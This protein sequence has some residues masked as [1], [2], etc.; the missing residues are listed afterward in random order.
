MAD[1]NPDTYLSDKGGGFNPDAYL[2]GQRNPPPAPQ[3]KS[4]FRGAA[5]AFGLAAA[6]EAIK[7]GGAIAGAEVGAEGGA[8]LG[9]M[10][11][12]AAPITVP[13]GTILGGLAGGLAGY[14][15][16]GK[17][18]EKFGQKPEDIK[19]QEAEH[20]TASTLGRAAVDVPL[21]GAGLYGLAKTLAPAAGGLVKAG[22]GVPSRTTEEIAKAFEKRGYK[23]EPGQLK[24]DDPYHSPG[25]LGNKVA[26]QKL[27]NKEVSTVTGKAAGPKGVDNKFLNERFESL[28]KKYDDIIDKAPEWTIDR[29]AIDA[30]KEILSTERA[31]V[32]GQVRPV[33]QVASQVDKAFTDAGAGGANVTS[34]KVPAKDLKRTLSELKKI[35]RTSRDG[36][37]KFAATSAIDAIT[38]S[39]TRN[40]PAIA[41]ELK[42]VNQQYRATVALQDLA[43]S[44]GI[45]G[46]NVSLRKLGAK[47]HHLAGNPLYDLAHG[48]RELNLAAR[49]EGT[50]TNSVTPES[51]LSP[52]KLA[53]TL[54][55]TTGARSQLARG[56]QRGFT[57]D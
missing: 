47:A 15:G 37:D 56:I 36:N 49:W 54:A 11:G 48:G 34:M 17:L 8:A 13:A 12:P 57:G 19:K 21:A 53:R 3:E 9:A 38:G 50:G 27:A 14:Y 46:G 24:A 33:M 55:T 43:D 42:T 52:S 39:L 28:G 29:K 44:G 5:K 41:S 18:G 16:M 10:G 32:P 35:A 1:F 2:A 4:G 23:L 51:L 6:P 26:N 30:L 45:R 22:L 7:S 40:H 25:F 31:A 20:P